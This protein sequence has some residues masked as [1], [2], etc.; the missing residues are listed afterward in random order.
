MTLKELTLREV[1]EFLDGTG[2]VITE[3]D[4]IEEE[5]KNLDY[6]FGTDKRIICSNTLFMEIEK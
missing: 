1:L 6:Q 3:W 2:L 4:L 5:L